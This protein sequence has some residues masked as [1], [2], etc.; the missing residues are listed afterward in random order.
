[1]QAIAETLFDAVYL[2]S[3]ITLGIIMIVKSEKNKEIPNPA[4]DF[5]G[6]FHLYEDSLNFSDDFHE[7]PALLW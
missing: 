4:K 5:A 3:V 6:F 1:M 2:L 7:E